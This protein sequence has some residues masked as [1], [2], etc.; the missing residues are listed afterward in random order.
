MKTYMSNF[1]GEIV[2]GNRW[3][4]IREVWYTIWH[5]KWTVRNII[6]Y[7]TDWRLIA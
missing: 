6:R 4:V 5:Y 3:A 2:T 7:A 1:T